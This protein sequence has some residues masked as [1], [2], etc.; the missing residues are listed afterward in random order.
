MFR[1]ASSRFVRATCMLLPRR[2]LETA[3]VHN[4]SF[5]PHIELLVSSLRV[6]KERLESRTKVVVPTMLLRK[7]LAEIAKSAAFDEAF[8]RTMYPDLVEASDAGKIVDLREHFVE[9]GYFE[10]R[11]G[12]QPNVDE[13]YYLQTYPDV[14]QAIVAGT[15]KTALEH[16]LRSGAAEG[17]MPTQD[18]IEAINFWKEASK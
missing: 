6:S 8:Y 18:S 17:R 7:I 12:T 13:G 3:P 1:F 14:R 11:F 2:V 15:V 5:L 4:P 10:G 16:Y 9:Q